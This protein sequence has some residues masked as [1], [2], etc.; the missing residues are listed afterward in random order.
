MPDG[1][2]SGQT[3]RGYELRE[4]I[5]AGGF[6]AVYRAYQSAVRREVAVKVILPQFANQ[7]EFIRRFEAEAEIVAR[8]EHPYI[9]PLY[10]FWRDPGGAYLVMRWLSG[11]SLRNLI[12]RERLSL[13]DLARILDQ[14]GAALGL[15]HRRGVIHL[16]LKPDNILLDDDRN[17]FLADFGIAKSL[18]APGE[19]ENYEHG[20]RVVSGTPTYLAPEQLTGAPVTSK[21]DIYSLGIM[22]YELL[23]GEPPF[24]RLTPTQLMQKHLFETLPP[25]AIKRADLPLAINAVVQKTTAKNPDERY[26]DAPS[27]AL[28]FRQ[29]LGSMSPDAGPVTDEHTV[30]LRR[31]PTPASNRPARPDSRRVPTPPVPAADN[32]H[33]MT[34]TPDMPFTPPSELLGGRTVT[35]ADDLRVPSE[36]ERTVT[37][38]DDLLVPSEFDRTIT[39]ADEDLPQ[40]ILA[41]DSLDNPYK[42]LRAFE[43]ADAA[44]FFGREALVEQLGVRLA[45]RDHLAR[46]LAV[47]GPSGSGKSSAI[48]AGLIPALRRGVIRELSGASRWFVV[49]MTPTPKLMR[50]PYKIADH[51]SR[52]CS[53]LPIKNV[54]PSPPVVP[55]GRRASMMSSCARSYGFW[56]DSHGAPNAASTIKTNS[57]R[58]NTAAKRLRLAAAYSR[59]ARR[60]SSGWPALWQ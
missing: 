24:P 35:P 60:S 2:L 15:A 49:E 41:L 26:P 5:G 16:D 7:P 38:A 13:T 1:D 47:V 3:I 33:E 45:Q 40:I 44:D 51:K 43:E 31:A 56:I 58:P 32:P 4:S 39:P 34:V 57:A 29:A 28:A 36:F 17:G 37:P 14:I 42:G 11:G 21:A 25:L 59:P 27:V 20:E 6:G 52:P 48:K 54:W 18:N 50:K 53:S 9:V 10:D 19:G 22:L 46:F 8:L 23:V 55:G 30:A 12:R